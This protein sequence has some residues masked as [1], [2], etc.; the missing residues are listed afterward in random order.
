MEPPFICNSFQIGYPPVLI[1]KFESLHLFLFVKVTC[2]LTPVNAF[3]L[4]ITKEIFQ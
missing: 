3:Y 1:S 4:A 2:N